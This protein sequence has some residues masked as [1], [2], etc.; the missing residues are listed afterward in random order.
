MWCCAGLVV[1]SQLTWDAT[2]GIADSRG[3]LYR[4]G[5]VGMQISGGDM[6]DDACD[7]QETRNNIDTEILGSWG[8]S[9]VAWSGD[10]WRHS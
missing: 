5:G 8:R 6:R 9:G 4:R 1:Q 10:S 3:L 7:E 2:A